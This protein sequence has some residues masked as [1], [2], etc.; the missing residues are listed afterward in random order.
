MTDILVPIPLN[1]LLHGI[2]ITT[3][4]PL[5]SFARILPTDLK[6]TSNST[7]V[8][9]G[10]ITSTHTLLPRSPSLILP[11]LPREATCPPGLG[12]VIATRQAQKKT[13]LIRR[14]S[15]PDHTALLLIP[16][17][18]IEDKH[19]IL[20]PTTTMDGTVPMNTSKRDI[21]LQSPTMDTT[22]PLLRHHHRPPLILTTLLLLRNHSCHVR[23][24]LRRP[25][26]RVA[27]EVMTNTMSLSGL[28][29]LTTTL[30]RWADITIPI[31]NPLSRKT[32]NVPELHPPTVQS[33]E[34]PR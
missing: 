9:Q 26:M 30:I 31:L 19:H 2:T 4:T 27:M 1:I 21:L 23:I 24:P 16:H 32:S 6:D 33:R 12:R 29:C 7:T 11:I 20:R 13:T 22:F 25:G 34:F 28:Q 17:T 14:S 18:R 15:M 3:T 8:N 10:Q 5:T